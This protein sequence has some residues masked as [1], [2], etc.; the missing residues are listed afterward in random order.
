MDN[1][2]IEDAKLAL[3]AKIWNGTRPQE[4]ATREETAAMIQRAI[5]SL[6]R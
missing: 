1:I 6:Q 2:T 3:E 5:M 4:T